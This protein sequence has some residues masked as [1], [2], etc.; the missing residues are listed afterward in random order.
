MNG[1]PHAYSFYYIDDVSV[2]L[3]D[4][5]VGINENDWQ[6][7]FT[8]SPN[9]AQNSISLNNLPKQVSAIFIYDLQGE[10]LL[11]ENDISILPCKYAIN[12]S[13]FSSGI[14]FVK[15]VTK[16]GIVTRKIMKE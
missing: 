12:I 2:I 3:C 13:N 10:M 15:V 1:F 9:P 7:S 14:Y 6:K 4:S 11:R 8:I 5:T 16:E